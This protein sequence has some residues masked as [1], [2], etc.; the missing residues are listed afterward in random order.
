MSVASST[1][2]ATEATSSLHALPTPPTGVPSAAPPVV[3]PRSATDPL[4]ACS[5]D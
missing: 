2:V 1:A 5:P 4:P 3:E